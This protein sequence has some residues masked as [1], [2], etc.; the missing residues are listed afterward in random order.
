MKTTKIVL[1]LFILITTTSCI[2]GGFGIKG[3]RNVVSEDRKI[4]ADFT[5]I[6]VSQGIQ[7]FLT[8]G[9]DINI[10]VEADEN[11]IDLLITEVKGDVLKIYFD[12]NVSRAK[13]KNVYLTIDKITGIKVSSGAHVKS[14]G[15]IRAKN[16]DLSST[17]GSGLKL[18]IN[19][20]KVTCSTSSGANVKLT[21]ETEH[22]SGSSSSGS[23]I[24]ANNLIAKTSKASA[25][26]GAGISL[27]ASET[28]NATAS[29][30]GNISYKG[31]PET[32]NK[33]KSS[34]GS[35]SKR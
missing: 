32:V 23:N 25:S 17:S 22:F 28:L 35:I 16:L 10:N 27:F 14:E 13:A 30:G 20:S 26:S 24:N 2:N 29:S 5:E 18:N 9:N 33:S 12:K 19:A 7:V 4:T 34:G 3:N 11:I 6:K 8:Q 15:V 21:G 31:N 1:A